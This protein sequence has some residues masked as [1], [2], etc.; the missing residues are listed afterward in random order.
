MLYFTIILNGTKSAKIN[1]ML[2][3]NIVGG[4]KREGIVKSSVSPDGFARKHAN[5][6]VSVIGL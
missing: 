1:L 3:P 4:S 5:Y 6:A 2:P